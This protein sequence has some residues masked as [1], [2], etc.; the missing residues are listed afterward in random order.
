MAILLVRRSALSLAAIAIMAAH[1]AWA[2]GDDATAEE[3]KRVQARLP[4][5]SVP[6][7]P[8]HPLSPYLKREP[9]PEEDDK[10]DN[11]PTDD[12]GQP[13]RGCDVPW[14]FVPTRR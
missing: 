6:P 1:G 4:A 11:W 7:S 12:F 10:S 8:D 13:L 2:Q 9:Q 3:P 5:S 14:D